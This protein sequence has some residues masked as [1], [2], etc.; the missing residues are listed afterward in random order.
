MVGL[1]LCGCQKE[2]KQTSN[3]NVCDLDCEKADM[4]AYESF[5][6]EDHVF[7]T[8]TFKQADTMLN[9]KNFSGILY[10]GYATC[11]WCNEALPIMNEVAKADKLSIYYVDK[12][13]EA[14]E[15]DKDGV[16]KITKLLDKAY[17]LQKDDE[18]NANI[19][20]PEVVVVK[21]GKIVSHHMGTLEEHD[22]TQRKMTTEEQGQ[23][24]S[25]YEDMFKVLE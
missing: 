6:D 5:K 7:L 11:P 2:V 12:H 20:V 14:N 13:S 22:A 21:D 25:I 9:D 1:L 3:K 24:K 15:K 8:T 23:L 16:A 19:F 17:G 18:G 10:F 4:G